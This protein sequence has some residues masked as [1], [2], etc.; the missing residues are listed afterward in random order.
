MPAVPDIESVQQEGPCGRDSAGEAACSPASSFSQTHCSRSGRLA[1]MPGRDISWPARYFSGRSHLGHTVCKHAAF[2][3]TSVFKESRHNPT[4]ERPGV[5]R[6]NTAQS[7]SC[8]KTRF[9][10]EGVLPTTI[11]PWDGLSSILLNKKHGGERP[12]CP[13]KAAHLIFEC[14]FSR[15]YPLRAWSGKHAARTR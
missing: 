15:A 10:F 11:S 7:T 5:S 13:G 4:R 12:L 14:M 9:S 3:S 2:S 8:G 1:M 6:N